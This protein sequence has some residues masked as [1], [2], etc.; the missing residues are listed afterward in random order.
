M[1][2]CVSSLAFFVFG[3]LAGPT[4]RL[5]RSRLAVPLGVPVVRCR[6]DLVSPAKVSP[7][8]FDWGPF[9]TNIFEGSEAAVR[10]RRDSRPRIR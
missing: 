2:A 9:K 1:S 6:E 5:C 8:A 7:E 3:P 10:M 4:C